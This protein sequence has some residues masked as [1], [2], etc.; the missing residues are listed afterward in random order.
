MQN[1]CAWQAFF[2]NSMHSGIYISVPFCR[3]KCTY[4][5]FASGVFSA[6]QMGHYVER[7]IE[8]TQSI[9]AFAAEI[10]AVVPESSDSIYLGGGTPSLLPPD[11][12]KKLFSAIRQKFAVAPNTE[13][14][15]ECAPGTLADPVIETLTA[16]GVN[17]VSLGVQSFVDKEAASVAR[18]HTREKTLSDIDRLRQAGI[19]NI[20]VDLIA[21]LPHQTRE[22]WQY[23]LDQTIATGVPHVS[24]Y[25]LEVDEDSRLG[26]ELI[27]GGTKYHA[28]FVPDD[29]LTAEFYETACECL[30]AAGVQQYEISNFARTGFESRHNLKYWTRQPYLGFGV[31]AHSMLAAGDHK[32]AAGTASVRLATTDD[33]D[34]YFIAPEWKSDVVKRQQALEESFFLGLRLNRGVDLG[35]LREEFGEESKRYDEAIAELEADGLLQYSAGNLRLTPRGRLLSNEVFEKFIAEQKFTISTRE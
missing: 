15:V 19:S 24:I 17:R 21:G 1:L 4:C 2:N 10:G 12:L 29:D 14:T 6:G 20:N 18:L 32:R 30:N 11:D 7:V 9:R 23:S 25:M 34:R 8:D 5:N 22:S 35:R 3:S 13:I 28:H 26:R 16:L 27:A 33:Y 31:D